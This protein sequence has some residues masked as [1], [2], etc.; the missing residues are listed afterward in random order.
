[1]YIF[2]YI[3]IYIYIYIHIHIYIYVLKF[4]IYMLNSLKIVIHS[5]KLGA[6]L[7]GGSLMGWRTKLIF[8]EKCKNLFG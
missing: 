2:I 7:M 6:R 4:A 5:H 1:M 8:N 3:S